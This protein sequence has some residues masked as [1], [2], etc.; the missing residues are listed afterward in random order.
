MEERKV[1]VGKTTEIPA[2]GMKKFKLGFRS[3][4]VV[5]V[6]TRFKAYYDFC[7]HQGGAL[8]IKDGQFE[9]LR[10]FST[11]DLETGAR[12][13]GQAPEGSSL[14]EIPLVC[15]GEDIFVMWTP[16]E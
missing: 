5:A 9:C 6:G 2:G 15:E 11:F 16:P 14:T 10:H 7:T 4:L 3:A 8:K 1:F 13:A 12:R